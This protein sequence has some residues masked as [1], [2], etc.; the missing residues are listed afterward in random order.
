MKEGTAYGRTLGGVLRAA[1]LD[2]G[3]SQTDLAERSGVPKPRL[4]RYENNHVV[5]SLQTFVRL[6]AALRITAGSILDGP[7]APLLE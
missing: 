5:P 1:R 2:A 4:S 7:G 6:C 3:M